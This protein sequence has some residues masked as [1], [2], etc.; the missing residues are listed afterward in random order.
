MRGRLHI[1]NTQIQPFYS[2]IP[3]LPFLISHYPLQN[4][5]TRKKDCGSSLYFSFFC[6]VSEVISLLILAP[7][8]KISWK[9]F[10]FKTTRRHNASDNGGRGNKKLREQALCDSSS[11]QES[12]ST[13]SVK[14]I[15]RRRI[16]QKRV[17]QNE[18]RFSRSQ[19]NATLS[20]RVSIF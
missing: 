11:S 13:P 18:E 7:L 14:D 16:E 9:E 12:S 20:N 6:F 2:S 1:K 19:D 3:I 4:F 17:Q 15:L 8:K 5:H 10:K